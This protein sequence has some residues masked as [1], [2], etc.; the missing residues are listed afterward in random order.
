MK[1]FLL[2]LFLSQNFHVQSI[3]QIC[4]LLWVNKRILNVFSWI[5]ILILSTFASVV[6]VVSNSKYESFLISSYSVLKCLT[7]HLWTVRFTKNELI[8]TSFNNS[9]HYPIDGG[10]TMNSIS[11]SG[12]INL[13]MKI[14]LMKKSNFLS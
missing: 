1:F 7:N 12:K 13:Q 2:T 14:F 5:K 3:E 9:P 4:V 8:I 10:G 6:I 11:F